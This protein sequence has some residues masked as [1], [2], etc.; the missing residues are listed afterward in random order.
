MRI[1]HFTPESMGAIAYPG[2]GISAFGETKVYQGEVI[3][4]YHGA[5]TAEEIPTW[6]GVWPLTRVEYRTR[7]SPGEMLAL[8][9]EAYVGIKLAAYPPG[10]AAPD[11]TALFFIDSANTP[12]SA[13]GLIVVN[14]T[15]VPEA[16]AYFVFKG[17]V[18]QEDADR[19]MRGVTYEVEV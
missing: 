17:Y 7:V 2:E 11:N 1:V 16:M 14:E 9:G 5:A 18:T 12:Y 3:G 19:L 15:P 6:G 4:E 8:L 10:G 13:D